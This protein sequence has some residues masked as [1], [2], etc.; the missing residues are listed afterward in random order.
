MDPWTPAERDAFIHEA[1]NSKNRGYKG[2]YHYSQFPRVSGNNDNEDFRKTLITENLADA[3]YNKNPV[4]RRVSLGFYDMLIHKLSMNQYTGPYL[5]NNIMVLMKGSNAYC[6]VTGEKFPDDFKFSD[7]DIVIFINPHLDERFFVELEKAVKVTVL[8]TL[9]QYK[10]M[11]DH[12]FFVKQAGRQIDMMLFDE[13][14]VSAFKEDYK[15]M[16]D[17][18]VLPDNC[19]FVSPFESDEIRNYCSRNSCILTNSKVDEDKIVR[20]EVPHY[21]NCE[22]IPL[23]KTPFFCSY[24]ETIDF[25]RGN[26]NQ[27]QD[28]PN[29][30][31]HGHFDLYR[32]RFN[33][34]YI[35]KDVNGEV[36]SQDRVT[37]DFID[38]SIA[39][40]NDA[41]LLDFW[42]RGRCLSVYDRFANVWIMVP[43]IS[44]CID[45]LYKM[46]N[47]YDCPDGKKAKR[48]QKYDRLLEIIRY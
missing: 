3:I 47:V 5:G 14:T 12:M 24:N 4:Y 42:N 39:R 19:K 8:Q 31:L 27:V 23:R 37:A 29:E 21:Q 11:L 9:S 22:R 43:D 32:I 26:Q 10:R 6:Y 36:V 16:L 46:L 2:A 45:D 30:T 18:I 33:N 13:A 34:M 28:N 48:Q 25:S 41:E 17:E 20:V 40:K 15:N 38:V 7:M 35:E 1:I 44:A